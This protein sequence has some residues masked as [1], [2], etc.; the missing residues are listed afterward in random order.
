MQRKHPVAM[1]IRRSDA[2]PW[3]FWP[4]LSISEG[5]G[6]GPVLGPVLGPA[7]AP[8]PTR[9]PPKTPYTYA[10]CGP[11]LAAG[12]AQFR[13]RNGPETCPFWGP[14][15]VPNHDPGVMVKKP[16]KKPLKR[17]LHLLDVHI[18]HKDVGSQ[19]PLPGRHFSRK[20]YPYPTAS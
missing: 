9:H 16:P 2:R 13:A 12:G 11:Q 19:P 17:H 5:T 7:L 1:K 6:R 18:P 3:L 8:L 10:N 20:I 4:I 15:R 14:P